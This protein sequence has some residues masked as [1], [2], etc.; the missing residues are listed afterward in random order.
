MPILETHIHIVNVRHAY[1][2]C[3]WCY[4]EESS[5]HQPNPFKLGID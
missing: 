2:S 1:L 4:S 3:I 5:K